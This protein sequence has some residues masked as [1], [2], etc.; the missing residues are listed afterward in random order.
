MTSIEN[1]EDNELKELLIKNLPKKL[2][3]GD[4]KSTS[5]IKEWYSKNALEEC[6]FI[7]FN[8]QEKISFLVFDIDTYK[9]KTALEHFK[10]I[11]NFLEY[12]YEI[13]EYEPTFITQ[14][15]K[16]FHFAY[17]LKNWVF[18]NKLKSLE[19]VK[20]IKKAIIDKVKCDV[21]GSSRLY[22]VWR[23]PLQHVYYYSEQINYEL[24]D[25][26]HLL[27]KRVRR[28]KTSSKSVVF[29]K[30]KD[31]QTGNRN[32][33]LFTAA[34]RY[35]NNKDNTSST[36][37][38]DYIASVNGRIDNPLLDDEILKIA[39]SVYKYWTNGTINKNFGKISIKEKDY[40]EGV[41]DFPK[42]VNLTTVQYNEETKRRQSLSAKR[43][44]EIRDKEKN[45]TQ[46]KKAREEYIQKKNLENKKLI[47]GAVEYFIAN[48]EKINVSKIAKYCK[49]GRRT[50]KK[51][52]EN[53]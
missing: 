27:P 36:D 6:K 42:M 24:K 11:N 9:D 32:S 18:T 25:F 16:G 44:V 48:N 31:I 46:L 7:N 37:I 23:N 1:I 15:K 19:Y 49:I 21:H 50:V 35:A 4:T 10:N 26:N 33:S 52:I 12:L 30:I 8:S 40:N 45:K 14:T 43:T 28:K 20:A 2:K 41:M 29:T 39:N 34:M 13:V 38:L 3:A 53:L 17:H 47:Q 22:G 5:N 51:V